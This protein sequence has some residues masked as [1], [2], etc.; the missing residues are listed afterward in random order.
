[1]CCA[2]VVDGCKD[3]LGER[4]P[5][6]NS[7]QNDFSAGTV[8]RFSKGEILLPCGALAARGRRALWL[9]APAQRPESFSAPVV[10][11]QGSS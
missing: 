9:V 7:E 4:H 11:L 1:M 6:E 2:E 8:G 10:V 5:L 3:A